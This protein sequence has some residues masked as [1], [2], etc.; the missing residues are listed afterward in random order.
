MHD[1]T[2]ILSAPDMDRTKLADDLREIW[3][4][5][6]MIAFWKRWTG[7]A[8]CMGPKPDFMTGKALMAAMG[9]TRI[10]AHADDIYAELTGYIQTASGKKEL[11][12]G[13][14]GSATKLLQT[15]KGLARLLP[16]LHR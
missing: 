11:S 10:S 9:M 5:P 1:T 15:G 6:E 16:R 13:E 3:S 14:K 12:G 8:T 7:E 2:P 4:Q